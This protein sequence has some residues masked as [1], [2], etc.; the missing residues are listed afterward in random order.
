L[1][2]TKDTSKTFEEHKK[3][4][5]LKK[6]MAFDS[7]FKSAEQGKMKSKEALGILYL[8]D[9]SCNTNTDL[10][11]KYLKSAA[12]QDSYLALELLGNVYR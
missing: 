4:A 11:V 6:T 9:L 12:R 2:K 8:C 7:L 3:E 10:S 1:N 5:E